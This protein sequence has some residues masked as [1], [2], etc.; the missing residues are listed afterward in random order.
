MNIFG[1]TKASCA[2]AVVI[3]AIIFPAEIMACWC[4]TQK[5][6]WPLIL[7]WF[8]AVFCVYAVAKFRRDR[9]LGKGRI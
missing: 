2:K 9:F 8:G 1:Y 3:L 4:Y 6:Y 5:L 7:I